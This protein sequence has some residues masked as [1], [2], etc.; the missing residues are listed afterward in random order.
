ME[1]EIDVGTALEVGR[2][3]KHF[4]SLYLDW[5]KFSSVL[6]PVVEG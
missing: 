2:P 1:R 5:Y 3:L 6:G 4:L